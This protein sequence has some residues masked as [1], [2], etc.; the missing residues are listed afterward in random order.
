MKK[1]IAVIF[2]STLISYIFALISSG[3]SQVLDTTNK[4]SVQGFIFPLLLLGTLFLIRSVTKQK[5]E[6]VS[7]GQSPNKMVLLIACFASGGLFAFL[8]L[9]L[10]AVFLDSDGVQVV[11]SNFVWIGIVGSIIFFPFVK[12]NLKK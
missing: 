11:F 5:S 7:P 10:S 8:C 2:V 12:N 1:I 6:V 9:F 3:P 4:Y